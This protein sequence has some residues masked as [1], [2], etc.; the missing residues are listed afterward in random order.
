[1]LREGIK[2]PHGCGRGRGSFGQIPSPKTPRRSWERF[3]S[4][5]NRHCSKDPRKDSRKAGEFCADEL[6]SGGSRGGSLRISSA[7]RAASIIIPRTF[8][9]RLRKPHSTT[10]SSSP[11]FLPRCILTSSSC[12]TPPLPLR[13]PP[14][15]NAT[16][17]RQ[18]H[19]LFAPTPRRC[20]D[21]WSAWLF[22]SRSA[23]CNCWA[24]TTANGLIRWGSAGRRGVPCRLCRRT[25]WRRV[26]SAAPFWRRW[27]RY[28]LCCSGWLKEGAAVALDYSKLSH[29]PFFFI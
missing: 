15:A 9:C 22:P 5:S 11:S 12:R 3:G 26:R 25:S 6:A 18:H 7:R 27:R 21:W 19:P 20:W 4:L 28:V 16:R 1:M 8:F 2:R 17:H 10:S 13:S 24:R 14:R 23:S 29:A